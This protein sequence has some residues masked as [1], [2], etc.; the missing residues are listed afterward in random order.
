MQSQFV[1]NNFLCYHLSHDKVVEKHFSIRRNLEDW[2]YQYNV[3]TRNRIRVVD[4]LLQ[5]SPSLIVFF[6]KTVEK[7]NNACE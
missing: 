6:K 5:T 3:A 4:Y 1:P 7:Y 2:R